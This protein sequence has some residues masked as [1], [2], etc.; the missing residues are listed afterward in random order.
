MTN[1]TKLHPRASVRAQEA[2]LAALLLATP[3]AAFAQETAS[4]QEANDIEEVIVTAQR[5]AESIQDVPIAVTAL[6]GDMLEDRQ[7]V[8]PSDLQIN[9][10]NVSFTA[11][12]F[13]GSSFS[14]RGIGNLVIGRTGESGV[15]A[16]LNE[17]AVPAN[18]NAVEFFDMERVE[19][20]RGPQGT[21]FGRNATGG[22]INFVTRMPEQGSLAG[23]LDL[24]AGDYGHRRW[25]GATNLPLGDA[26]ALRLSGFKLDRDGYIE[27]LAHGQRDGAG[28]SLPGINGDVDGRDILALRATLAWDI[29]ERASAWLQV[30]RFEEDDDR[31]RITNQVCERNALPTT[32][33]TPDGFG[34]ESPNL[35][36][37]TGGIF[38]G[39]AGALPAGADGSDPALYDFPRPAGI[40]YRR[41]HT[42][43]EPVFQDDEEIWAFGVDLDF[44]QLS[45]SLIGARRE[46]EYLSRQDYQMDVG[47][48][49]S[50]T[51]FNPL[52]V[53]PISAPAGGAGA[54]W[55]SETCNLNDGTSGVFGGCLFPALQNRVFAYDQQ[56]S[57][58]EFWTVEAKI[59]SNFEGPFGFLFGTSLYEDDNYGGY[60]VLANTLDL[61]SLYGSPALG[62]PPLYPG[63][64]LNSN[65]P[66]GGA[67]SDGWA[68]FGEI[69][70]DLSERLK[71]T[72]GLR[73]NE[74]NKQTSDSSALFN[75]ANANTALGGLLGSGNVWIRSG[76][77]GEMAAMAEGAATGLSADS[78]RLLEFW[79]AQSVW[80]DNGQTAVALIAAIGAA[81]QIGGL[82]QAGALPPQAVPAAIAGLPL[83]PLFQA[84]VAALL[85]GNP[86]AINA[87]AGLAAGATAFG[88]IAEA[89]PPVPG[90]GETRF[91]TGSPSTASWRKVSGRLGLD[92][93][94]SND[95]LLYGFYSRGY[96]PGGFNPAIPPAFQDTSAFTFDA[97]QVNAF[98]AGAK[99]TL[100][101]GR[102]MLNGAVFLYDY[103]GLQV[104]RI[105][106]NSSINDNIDANL[107]GVELE[108]QWR[109]DALPG[110]SVDFA[111][112]WLGSEVDGSRSLD[113]INRTGGDAA[114]VLL[115]NIDPGS[116]TG[117]NYV[118][119]AAQISADVVAAALAAG[120]ALD[121]RNG[122]TVRSV[123]YPANAAGASIPA[124]FSRRFLAAAGVETLEG[125]PV[126][127][128]GN[129]LPNAPEHT[130]RLGLAHTWNAANGATLTGRW[131]WYW[132]SD[133]YA[134]EFNTMGDEIDAWSQHN[135]SLIYEREGWTVKAWIRNILDDDNVTGKYLTS[136][137]SGFF[138]NYFLTE[139]R[140]FG[141]SV[142]L[143]FGSHTAP[144]PRPTRTASPSVSHAAPSV[145]KTAPSV[146]KAPPPVPKL[147][148]V[149]PTPPPEPT[150]PSLLQPERPVDVV[151]LFDFD[152]ANIKSS[153][154]EILSRHANFL[155]DRDDWAIRIEGHC[156]VRGSNE[157]NLLLGERRANA[158]RDVL[159]SEGISN[160]RIEVVSFGEE[161]PVAIGLDDTAYARNRRAVI[162]HL[163]RR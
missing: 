19:V 9:A 125:V 160:S 156:D 117:V 5:V 98:E 108:G 15:S 62:A 55:L 40:G 105:R 34:W 12:N 100:L 96:K 45:A 44:G 120:A 52:S 43:F 116:L 150:A 6:T 71:F 131:D 146:P 106:N 103:T 86:A 135:A 78:A 14:I 64:F 22:A 91:V 48:S 24:E 77:F 148:T 18:L 155:R 13:G 68:T 139:P 72:A 26:V 25:K 81:Q 137:T 161:R 39:A 33:C 8:T 140:I 84:T 83:P 74:D 141:V 59:H 104:T 3:G 37:T 112:G 38:G 133:S 107:M 60:Y 41:M 70:V 54:E 159:V 163:V 157:Y 130:L 101:D 109:P 30:G 92:Y 129:E 47:P 119:R 76:L 153:D 67:A 162:V 134:R 138:R 124:Y 79:N 23:F 36:S 1:P 123:S 115:N 142:R 17:I 57:K 89:V 10:P 51:P 32:G 151:I 69:Y 111:Y 65:N 53:W 82:V 93:Q 90:F 61:V 46:D 58:S 29:T 35:G 121:V 145:S 147:E 16:H 118:A 4:P 7:V 63:F 73:F 66:A 132:Q 11:T 28:D 85:S 31:V 87:D 128:D 154:M 80:A 102:L 149:P 56:D 158:V 126:D 99:N 127:L 27:N 144:P 95:T 152:K 136:D 2:T 20:L 49:L 97:E 75:S 42:D 21:L 50:A 122:A 113:P 88:A 143:D 114:Y 94:L 110:L